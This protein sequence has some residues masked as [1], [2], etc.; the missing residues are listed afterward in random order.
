[1][2]WHD[3]KQNT[4]QWDALR[5]GKPTSSKLGVVMA[6]YGKAF[7]EPAKKYAINIAVEQITGQKSESSYSN[8]HMERGHEQEPL[9][10]MEYEEAFFCEVTNGGFFDN[11]GIGCSPDGLVSE[12]GL[13]EIKSVIPSVHYD[14]IRRGD[15]DPAYKWQCY[16][17]LM[18]TEREYL[19]FISY[20]SSFPEGKRIYVYRVFAEQIKFEF[21]MLDWRV[22]EFFD[23]IDTAKEI[24][25]NTDYFLIGKKNA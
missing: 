11:L 12:N 13:I 14:N 21:K 18:I 5:I 4:E 8:E 9:A 17:N 19:D 25:L 1:M 3:V 22:N 10:R 23:L 7:G 6:N 20:C 24:I 16:G 15:I 2:L